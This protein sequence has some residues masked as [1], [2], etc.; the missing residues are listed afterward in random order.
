MHLLPHLLRI[1]LNAPTASGFHLN[2]IHIIHIYRYKYTNKIYYVTLFVV[3]FSTLDVR[4]FRVFVIPVRQHRR[5][6]IIPTQNKNT[7]Q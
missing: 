5:P 6:T 1:S 3:D 4:D 7:Q 2:R